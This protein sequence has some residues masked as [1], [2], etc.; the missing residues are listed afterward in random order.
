MV[1]CCMCKKR[2]AIGYFGIQEPDI[3]PIPLC[4][5]CK[6]EQQIKIFEELAKFTSPSATSK[7]EGT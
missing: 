6:I 7:K 5:G 3:E 1:I 2:K 4:G